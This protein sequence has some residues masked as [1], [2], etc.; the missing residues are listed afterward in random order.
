[1]LFT[2]RV[3]PAESSSRLTQRPYNRVK[4]INDYCINSCTECTI[5]Y[6][7]NYDIG[8][9]HLAFCSL[10]GE[11]EAMTEADDPDDY[12]RHLRCPNCGN[13]DI[14]YNLRGHDSIE[15]LRREARKLKSLPL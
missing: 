9:V 11:E 8:E 7:D 12:D 1:M 3:G 2:E 5:L 15:E 4:M 14:E 6:E 13:I 10:V